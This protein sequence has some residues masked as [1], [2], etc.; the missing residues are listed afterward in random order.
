M[1]LY[2]FGFIGYKYIVETAHHPRQLPAG[3]RLLAALHPQQNPSPNFRGGFFYL[4]V[5]CQGLLWRAF[6]RISI[7]YIR[8]NL[9]TH[10]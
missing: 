10:V 7:M 9:D 3:P 2:K 4:P 8:M 5:I 1:P 6:L